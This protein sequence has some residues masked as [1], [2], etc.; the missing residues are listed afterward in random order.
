M[1]LPAWAWLPMSQCTSILAPW[2]LPWKPPRSAPI[3]LRPGSATAWTA[4][5]AAST[6][7]AP[8][9]KKP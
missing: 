3:R 8:V 9:E 6:T 4:R 1:L 7:S 2:V 5:S